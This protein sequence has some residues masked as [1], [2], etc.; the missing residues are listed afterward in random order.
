VGEKQ[1]RLISTSA[2]NRM[3]FFIVIPYTISGVR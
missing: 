1:K 3:D 2:R